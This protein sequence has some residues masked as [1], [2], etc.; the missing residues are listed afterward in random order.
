MQKS[1]TQKTL[2]EM[3]TMI[4]I[5]MLAPLIR[6]FGTFHIT[7]MVQAQLD[8][9]DSLN[10]TIFVTGS[11]STNTKGDKVILSLGVDTINKT[12]EK[13]LQ[14]NSKLMNK[15]INASKESGVQ[16]NETRTSSFTITP[17]Y[18]YTQH[19]DRGVLIGFTVSNS[20]Q[21]ESYHVANVSQWVNAACT[22]RCQHR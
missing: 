18:N 20:I 21:I 14:S 11:A 12:A 1:N 6:L 9:L 3:K 16:Q 8:S 19:G 5:A 10:N 2:I 13:A 7:F 15:V 22:G 17:N 4:I